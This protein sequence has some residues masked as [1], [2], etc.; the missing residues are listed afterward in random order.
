MRSHSKQ[1]REVLTQSFN[2][3]ILVDVFHGSDRVLEDVPVESWSYE[4]D[5]SGNIKS[6]G[7]GVIVYRSVNGESLLPT[8]TKG[9]V[10]AFRARVLF[11]LEVSAGDFSERVTLGWGRVVANP[12]GRDD[13][14]TVNG[15]PRVV[16]SRV[17]VEWDGL[18]VELQRRGFRFPES[19]PSLTSCW[20]ELRRITGFP[21]VA[22]VPDKPIPA[23]TV[24]E[25]TQGGRLDAVQ[26]LGGILGG[27]IV[28]NPDGALT[29]VPDVWGDVVGELTIGPNGTVIDLADEIDTDNV[30]T[31]VVGTF[32]TDDRKPIYAVA[33]VEKGDLAVGG[34]YPEYTR[35][36][37]SPLVKT[38]AQA[39][40]AVQ[41]VLTQSIGSQTYEV[42]I[43]CV[44]NPLIELGDVLRVVGHTR[45]LEGRVVKY[46]LSDSEVMNV[47]LEANRNLT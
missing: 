41:A 29:L 31:A 23:G 12:P 4:A 18:D 19:P 20:E 30:Y 1:L 26:T 22:N 40:A 24:W 32:E 8:G 46:S 25:A 6:G 16:A 17:P 45:E 38:Q 14:Q 11:T 28:V 9:V 34:D 3:R 27:R 42:P 36:Y 5:A 37:S 21:V 44:I 43:Q 2:R 10:S 33:T 7:K 13:V 39:D 15:A 35:Y 47:T